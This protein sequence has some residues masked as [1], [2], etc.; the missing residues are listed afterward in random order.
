MYGLKNCSMPS[1]LELPEFSPSNTVFLLLSFE[2]P[3]V[4]SQAG[5]LGV[6]MAE[7]SR[8]LAEEG[9]EAHLFFVG[10]PEL[11]GEEKKFDGKLTYHRWCQWISRYHPGGVYDGEDGKRLNYQSS[12]PWWIGE[13]VFQSKTYEG[14]HV[15]VLSEE[16]HTAATTSLLSLI[17]RNGRNACKPPLILWNA[18]NTYGFNQIDFPSLERSATITTV[19]KYMKHLMW[20]YGLDPLVIPNGI[21]ERWFEPIDGESVQALRK[22]CGAD[23]I[24]AKVGRFTPDKRWVMAVQSAGLLKRLGFSPKMIIRG[25]AEPHGEEVR[26]AAWSSGLKIAPIKLPKGAPL[27]DFFAAIRQ[28]READILDLQFFVPE[29]TLRLI[30]RS[31]DAV[32]ANSSHEPFGLVGLEVMACNGVAITGNT[33]EDYAQDFYNG[34]VAETSDPWELATALAFLASQPRLGETLR[35]T[36]QESARSFQWGQVIMELKRKLTYISL[37]RS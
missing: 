16:W 33:G 26:L 12:L 18:N 24:L 20:G 30:Y 9:H 29:S 28:N 8:A 19:S 23:F 7:L 15:V 1:T 37:T 25:G 32:L 36:G 10:D 27:N 14:K 6:R 21:P 22:A 34:I 35:K 3:D 5:G 31:A 13:H 11:P 2:G 17:A 4:Y